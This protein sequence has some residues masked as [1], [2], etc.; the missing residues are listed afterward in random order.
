[1]AGQ[2][3]ISV[4]QIIT[5]VLALGALAVAVLIYFNL[6][7]RPEDEIVSSARKL[8]G[9]LAD[10][11]L[12]EAAIE[13]YQ[14]ILNEAELN[15]AE[16]GAINYLIAKIYFEEI[17]DYQQAAAHYIR[18][19][20]LDENG[21]YYDEAG[22][23]LIAS[24][25]KMGRRLDARRELDAQASAHPDTA[26]GK[27]VAIVGSDKITLVDFNKALESIPESMRN[28]Y[29]SPEGKKEFLN[30]LIGRELIYHAA[31]REG[32]DRSGE[33]QKALKDIE[34]DYLVQYYTSKKIAPTVKPDTSEL[35]MYYEANKEKYDNQ[36]FDAINQNVAQDYMNY[37]GQKA[38]NEYISVL[39]QAEPVQ[40]F[41]ENLK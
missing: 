35:K 25:E 41:E 7:P 11:N 19:R 38:M 14:K 18:S 1:M 20:S 6:P 23:N 40:K 22:K 3:K 13:E 36:D 10:N 39:L 2:S 32:F 30:Q 5:M 33:M 28:Q 31:M 17:G 8:A 21:S 12:P 24:L 4:M 37:L 16:R 27:I 26:V 29:L 9:E 15:S 34:K